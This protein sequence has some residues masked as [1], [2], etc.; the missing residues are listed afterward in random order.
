MGR[1]TR[2]PPSLPSLRPSLSLF[3]F[4][5]L[6]LAHV[7][8][9]SLP[10]Q[11]QADLDALPEGGPKEHARA[12][13]QGHALNRF[14]HDD[15]TLRFDVNGEPFVVDIAYSDRAAEK[16]AEA[17]RERK[18]KE[19]KK[20]KEK[21]EKKEKK[22]ERRRRAFSDNAPTGYLPNGKQHRRISISLIARN[23]RDT[24]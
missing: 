18:K 7:C 1:R 10:A 23:T 3:V 16:E 14:L 22:P 15:A 13:A 17:D 5:C 8:S 9:A 4:L 20:E 19:K 12:Q 11:A 21:K 6:L 24:G 2:P